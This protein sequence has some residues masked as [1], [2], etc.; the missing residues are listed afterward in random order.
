LFQAKKATEE[1]VHELL[2]SIN[3]AS[4]SPSDR[5]ERFFPKFWP[6]L[7]DRLDQ[8][9]AGSAAPLPKPSTEELLEKIHAI[10]QDIDRNVA[11]L[12]THQG[13]TLPDVFREV[14]RE[15]VRRSPSTAVD[16]SMA[17]FLRKLSATQMSALESRLRAVEE[18]DLSKRLQNS[19]LL[20]ALTDPPEPSEDAS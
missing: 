4:K 14:R 19:A 9:P 7:K 16:R 3:S 15:P 12:L 6:D 5:L 18:E 2:V 17:E 11:S 13:P 20:A 8:I 1:G 10:A